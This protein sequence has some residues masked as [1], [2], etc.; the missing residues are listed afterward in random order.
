MPMTRASASRIERNT[1]GQLIG[2]KGVSL[3]LR[4]CAI[5]VDASAGL[6]RVILRQTFVNDSADA[7]QASYQFPLP[8]DAAV[9]GYAFTMNGRRVLGQIER[10]DEARKRFEEAVLEGR[11]AGLVEQHRSSLFTQEIG[12][13]PP[14]A[15]VRCELEIDQKLQWLEDGQ[16]EW[17]FPTTVAPRY[18]GWSGRVRDADRVAFEG[19][20]Q[21]AAARVK[22]TMRVRDDR[23][24]GDVLSPTHRLATG[25]D[26]SI[27]LE[28]P[29]GEPMDRDVVVRWAVAA[30]RIGV[31]VDVASVESREGLDRSAFGLVTVVPPSRVDDRA[32]IARDLILLLDTSGSM[33]GEPLR[34]AKSVALAL[35]ESLGPNDRLE[36]IAFSDTPERW[37][38][39]SRLCDDAVRAEAARWV[40]SL[41]A[42]GGT[43]MRDGVMEALECLRPDAQRQV[44]LVTDGLVGF[45]SEIVRA[46]R[47]HTPAACRVHTVAIGSAPNRSLTYAVAAAGGGTEHA[48]DLDDDP[49]AA[50]ARVVARLSKPTVVDLRLSGTALL[51]TAGPTRYD[52]VAGSPAL[53]P[54]R[55]RREG[56]SLEV[57]GRTASGEW[58]ERVRIGSVAPNTGSP[59]VVRLFGRALVERLEI[60]AASGDDVDA[61]IEEAGL[62]YR[63]ATRLTSWVAISEDLTVDPSDPMRR[64]RIAS[65]LPY[66]MSAEGL[67]LSKQSLQ[68]PSVLYQLAPPSE[69]VLGKRKAP[70]QFCCPPAA[71]L[72]PREPGS[73]VD[74]LRARIR[75]R[76]EDRVVLEFEL[77][78]ETEWDPVEVV[79]DGGA[80]AATI[81][82]SATTAAGSYTAGQVIRLVLTGFSEEVFASPTLS[83]EVRS[84]RGR[85]THLVV[86][87]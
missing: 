87:P 48:V 59:S 61:R 37:Y 10:T 33:E 80:S 25:S 28:C 14:G 31:S 41:R 35:I 26:G 84:G 40:R 1:G 24:T 55:L 68:G 36:M 64:V 22:L 6:A 85:S 12:N 70:I 65:Q 60:D 17:R 43:E 54:V 52:V 57:R 20:G 56:G 19:T 74:P 11:T 34:A 42:S 71:Y 5:E 72:R 18:M 29:D 73:S 67:E 44:V 2:P 38:L 15:E 63:I 77:D 75:W 21:P 30:P 58:V 76:G 8:A 78:C 45:E 69:R 83:V 53:I 50:A 39:V 82:R 27:S 81:D 62:M 9:G 86:L 66:G 16:W 4:G 49:A 13:I 23:R 47:R 3:P 7:L 51:E 79:V 32:V 46:V